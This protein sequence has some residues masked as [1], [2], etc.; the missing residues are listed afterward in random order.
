M[1]AD[2]CV[3]GMMVRVSVSVE[4]CDIERFAQLIGRAMRIANAKTAD[5]RFPAM[6][7]G[8]SRWSSAN[9]TGIEG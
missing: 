3:M 6:H 7:I 2:V 4:V 9:V 5:F 8:F 1:E